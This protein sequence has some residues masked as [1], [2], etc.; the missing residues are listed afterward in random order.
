LGNCCAL[1]GKRDLVSLAATSVRMPTEIA[2]QDRSRNKKTHARA[3]YSINCDMISRGLVEHSPV[4]A[5]TCARWS[6]DASAISMR[7]GAGP[8]DA[9]GTNSASSVEGRRA[10]ARS[11]LCDGMATNLLPADYCRRAKIRAT[12]GS[13]CVRYTPVAGVIRSI[14]AVRRSTAVRARHCPAGYH[15]S[16]GNPCVSVRT[17]SV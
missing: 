10:L 14:R 17:E 5:R 8:F 2:G 4:S 16:S 1:H 9:A 3:F 6:R 7:R 13:A 12:P 11:A 15:R